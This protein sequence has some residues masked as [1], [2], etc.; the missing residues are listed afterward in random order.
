MPAA[1]PPMTPRVQ[2]ARS[3]PRSLPQSLALEV[4][5]RFFGRSSCRKLSLDQP[6]GVKTA[7]FPFGKRGVGSIESDM[8]G[9]GEGGI[10]G[11]N[12]ISFPTHFCHKT[13]LRLLSRKRVKSR[14]PGFGGSPSSGKNKQNQV[15]LLKSKWINMGKLCLSCPPVGHMELGRISKSHD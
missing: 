7:P 5:G 1:T 12:S 11:G 6:S 14:F 9:V 4:G 3:V 13:S 2:V 15:K 10:G 8:L